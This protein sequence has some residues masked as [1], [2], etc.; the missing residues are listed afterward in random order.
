MAE[1]RGEVAVQ[2][3]AEGVGGGE[4][5][6]GGA[7]RDNAVRVDCFQAPR[8][9]AGGRL[10]HARQK[11]GGIVVGDHESSTPGKRFQKALAG[12]AVR[13]DIGVVGHPAG[14]QVHPV[15]DHP[16]DDE[17]MKAIARP[18]IVGAQGFEHQEW[19][20]QLAAVA[21]RPL[22]RKVP[23]GSPR[24]NHPVQDVFGAGVDGC[25]VAPTDTR[26]TCLAGGVSSRRVPLDRLGSDVL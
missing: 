9:P 7:H 15:V 21:D 16:L 20:P 1:V 5:A 3:A 13:L 14:L 8:N 22:Q 25:H 6:P 19:Q 10:Q 23:P 2:V 17:A 26:R 18:A 24:G 11:E 12:T 4:G